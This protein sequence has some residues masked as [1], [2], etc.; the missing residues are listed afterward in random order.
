MMGESSAEWTLY[1]RVDRGIF[2]VEKFIVTAGS[3][4][5]I[6]IWHMPAKVLEAKADRDMP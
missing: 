6:F 3:E 2:S 1:Q 4:G 5:A